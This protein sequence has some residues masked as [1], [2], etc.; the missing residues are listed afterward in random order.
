MIYDYGIVGAGVAGCVCAHELSRQGKRCVIFEKNLGP[1][2]KVCG[3]GVSY[4]ALRELESIGIDTRPLL[5]ADTKPVRGHRI[6]A[7]GIISTKIYKPGSISLGTQRVIFDQY[8]LQCA[9][10]CGAEIRYGTEVTDICGCPVKEIVWTAGAKPF[11]GSPV[12]GQSIGYSGQILAKTPL[13]DNIFHYWY[14]EMGCRTKYFWAF[15][16][17]ENLWNV[18]VW[19]RF[20]NKKLKSDYERCLKEYFLGDIQ[21]SWEY[22]RVPRGAFL[23]HVDQRG[24]RYSNGAG[25][26]AGMCNLQNGGGIIGAVKSAVEFAKSAN[27]RK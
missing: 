6:Y 24:A 27:I 22:Y 14:Y 20:P 16:I 1:T 4:K 9:I 18:G 8:L 23:G 5:L 19:S 10:G 12:N 26:F 2:E 11:P 7:D 15:P 21:G 13:L 17:G 3:G 25:D